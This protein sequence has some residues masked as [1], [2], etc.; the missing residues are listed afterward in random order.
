MALTNEMKKLIKTFP[1]NVFLTAKTSFF[2]YFKDIPYKD[3]SH[4]K[5]TTNIKSRIHFTTF[6]KF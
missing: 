6:S 2:I 5:F 4:K 3:L 1:L